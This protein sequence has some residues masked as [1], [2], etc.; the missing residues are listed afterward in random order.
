MFVVC[1]LGN[2]IML[3]CYEFRGSE[4][5]VLEHYNLL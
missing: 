3:K 1:R 2:I 4:K 5:Q